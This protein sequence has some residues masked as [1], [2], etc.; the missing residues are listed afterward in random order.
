[1]FY[2]YFHFFAEWSKG[3]SMSGYWPFRDQ[4]ASA[5]I[6]TRYETR[7]NV[8]KMCERVNFMLFRRSS[9]YH[10][11]S[12]FS[13]PPS[14][15]SSVSVYSFSRHRTR[16]LTFALKAFSAK[17]RIRIMISNVKLLMSADEKYCHDKLT[18]DLSMLAFSFSRETLLPRPIWLT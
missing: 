14:S 6:F 17:C 7:R 15:S 9:Y 8:A 5:R 12:L 13:T 11:L 4:C 16:R 2:I 1:M 10:S 18:H 3:K